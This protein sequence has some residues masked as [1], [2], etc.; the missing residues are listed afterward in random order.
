MF[1]IPGC[2]RTVKI[3]REVHKRAIDIAGWDGAIRTHGH[4]H[5]VWNIASGN[6]VNQC[7]ATLAN[8][9]ISTKVSQKPSDEV[10]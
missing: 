8:S 7:L 4:W 5:P 6:I 9:K 10:V 1:C 3:A 2:V